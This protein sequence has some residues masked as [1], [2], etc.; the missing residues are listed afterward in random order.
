MAE[1]GVG[2]SWGAGSDRL[3]GRARLGADLQEL[4]VAAHKAG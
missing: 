1:Q 4:L 3:G 2:P